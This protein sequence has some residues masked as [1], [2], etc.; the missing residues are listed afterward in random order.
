VVC[1]PADP[2]LLQSALRPLLKLPLKEIVAVVLGESCPDLLA[3]VSAV[4]KVRTVFLPDEHDEGRGRAAGAGKVQADAVLFADGW[5]PG[6]PAR[7]AAFL[8]ACGRGTDV[9]LN[10]ITPHLGTFHRWDRGFR[11]AAFLNMAFHRRD[12][13]A[14]SLLV[15]PFALSRRALKALGPQRLASPLQAQAAAFRR[16]LHVQVAGYVPLSSAAKAYA[17]RQADIRQYAAAWREALQNRG[18]RLSFPDRIRRRS[19]LTDG[20]TANV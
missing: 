5:R 18:H 17:A 9:A 10:N 6:K 8:K 2:N 13:G 3:A 4:P 12:L 15:P 19:V 16:G 11:M 14:S 1:V 7:L 20:L